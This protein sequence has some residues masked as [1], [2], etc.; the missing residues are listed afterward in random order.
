MQLAEPTYS[1]YA[2]ARQTPRCGV[3][4]RGR[5]ARPRSGARRATRCGRALRAAARSGLGARWLSKDRSGRSDEDGGSDRGRQDGG[6]GAVVLVGTPAMALPM[7]VPG[8][9][10]VESHPNASPAR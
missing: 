4:A 2:N 1:K 8:A 7:A 10:A 3:T 5:R 9:A 6:V